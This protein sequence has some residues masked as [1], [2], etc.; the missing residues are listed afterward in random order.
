MRFFLSFIIIPFVFHSF[1]FASHQFSLKIVNINSDSVKVS[2]PLYYSFYFSFSDSTNYNIWNDSSL[3]FIHRYAFHKYGLEWHNGNIG[4][5][6]NSIF[7]T[8]TKPDFGFQVGLNGFENYFFSSEPFKIFQTRRPYT[9]I[10]VVL[11]SN[12]EQIARLLHTQNV[13]ER[14]NIAF[15]MNRTTSE[16]FYSRQNANFNSIQLQSNYTSRNKR[17]A[18]IFQSNFNRANAFENGGVIDS[19]DVLNSEEF[20]NA[21]GIPINL[22][23]ARRRTSENSVWIKQYFNII[24]KDSVL[25]N[26]SLF[27][28]RYFVKA[29]L[30]NI[31]G[32]SGRY[33]WFKDEE[34]ALGFYSNFRDSITNDS[35]NKFSLYD[36]F[37][38][39]VYFNDFELNGGIKYEW[40]KLSM[41][42][43]DTLAQNLIT[44]SSLNWQNKKGSNLG[45]DANYVIAGFNRN[46]FRLRAFL[47]YKFSE[48]W[49]LNINY[50]S[51]YRTPTLQ[52]LR[53]VSNNFE[54]NNSFKKE[55][56]NGGSAYLI[57]TDREFKVGGG[58]HYL[59]N[60]V[61]YDF[62]ARP[63]QSDGSSQI[64]QALAEKTF[65]V[66]KFY[67]TNTFAYQKSSADSIFRV[68]EIISKNAFFFQTDLFKRAMRIQL[69][70]DFYY[71]TSF[72]PYA[73]MAA[74][75]VYYLQN[76]R[77]SGN[78]PF[79]D[80]F[81]NFKVKTLRG[82]I[83]L[84]HANQ[85]LI[86]NNQYY[87]MPGYPFPGRTVKLGL[88]WVF[89]D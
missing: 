59:T 52:S 65:Q 79:F 25:T 10:S 7:Y 37:R 67:L 43:Y 76:N 81:L 55:L 33:S 28:H 83:M 23:D 40:N 4:L 31:S 35:I 26:D 22:N 64:V 34:A 27:E 45:I 9:E 16:G 72:T 75:N 61:F 3:T 66:G 12:K 24:H 19:V 17:Y 60:P 63:K 2:Y 50:L 82:F 42:N 88:T 15:R 8:Y 29:G 11:G 62:V 56:Y 73:Y 86:G 49:F 77:L 13:N 1:S 53:W 71:F 48:E 68:P 47:N 85:G 69:G 44:V 87:F 14:W 54:W 18:A 78:Y 36:E 46:D 6:R 30:S 80:V 39:H 32:V 41:I 57:N 58:I 70:V 5:S 21:R 84:D 38:A 89:K 74:S 51:D 20:L